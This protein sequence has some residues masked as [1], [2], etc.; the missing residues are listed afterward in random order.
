MD[1]VRNLVNKLNAA[2]KAYDEGCPY[3]SDKEWDDLY[4]RLQEAE[5]ITGIIYPDSPTQKIDYQVASELKKV[6]HNH[7]MLSLAKT[8]DLAEIEAFINKYPVGGTIAML[9]MDGLTCSLTYK[10]HVLVR[11][12]TRGDGE[13]GEDVT[14]N[15]L[16][17]KNIPKRIPWTDEITIDG[18]I[19]CTKDDFEEFSDLYKNPRNF[20]SGSIRLLNSSECVSRKLKFI[21]WDVITNVR[22]TL[23]E[24]LDLAA[25]LGFEVV[26]WLELVAVV[27]LQKDV[28]GWLKE[29]AEKH[30]YPI[31]GLVFKY[32]SCELYN[33]L[34]FTDHHFRGG[35]AY[36]FY[37]ETY[38][39]E[40]RSLDWDVSRTGTLTPVA[41]F[42]PVDINGSTVTRASVHNLTLL[43]QTLGVPYE[44]E[45]LEVFKANEIIPQ[46]YSADKNPDKKVKFIDIPRNCP[47]CGEPLIRRKEGVAETLVCINNNCRGK[48]LTRLEHFVSKQC[49]DI[50]GL[51]RNTLENMYD[52]LGVKTFRDIYTLTKEQLAK[53]PGFAETSIN[54]V[55][56]SIQKSKDVKLS[57]FITSIGVPNIGSKQAEQI[58]SVCTNWNDFMNKAFSGFDWTIIDGFGEKKSV[59]INSYN[60]VEA[61]AV[62]DYLHIYNVNETPEDTKIT[63]SPVMNKKV[64]ITGTLEHFKNRNELVELL[65]SKGAIIQTG[66]NKQ[67]DLLINNDVFSS[68]AKNKKAKELG[69][70]I[71]SEEQFMEEFSIAGTI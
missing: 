52:Y 7:P 4:F 33:S 32:D 15:A 27:D 12:E 63:T 1:T 16:V 53:L 14:H 39:T 18:E 24:K 71:I 57:K 10:D 58:C 44:G 3:M 47:I 29:K 68:S 42:D 2:T 6:K 21:A 62:A 40:L 43:E 51:A 9:K 36:K 70:R 48:V 28:I 50:D 13:V 26:P 49:M 20:A 22:E 23:S 11:A 19:I 37:D 31:D 41:V 5:R 65:Q 17:L 67:T 38:S 46:I 60:Y 61:Q 64:V 45:H 66:V 8:K 54:N 30:S 55:Y 25:R 59:S 35:L 34:G 69:V 56:D